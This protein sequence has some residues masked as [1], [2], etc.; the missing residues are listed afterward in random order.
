MEFDGS[1]LNY[2]GNAA[3]VRDLIA[4][5][6][7]TQVDFGSAMDTGGGMGSA[8]LWLSIDG[9]EYLVNVLRCGPSAS[10]PKPKQEPTHER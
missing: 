8:D 10:K 7:R 1:K 3:Q 2:P 6:M 4:D 5:Q 9:A